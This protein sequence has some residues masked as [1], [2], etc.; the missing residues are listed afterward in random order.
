MSETYLIRIDPSRNMAR[1]CAM[2]V[3]PTLFGECALVREWGRLG[4]GGQARSTSY[5]SPAKAEQALE[6]WRPIK[7][8]RGYQPSK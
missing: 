6:E 2:R 3:E 1:Y 4:R 8:K 5:P 7:L